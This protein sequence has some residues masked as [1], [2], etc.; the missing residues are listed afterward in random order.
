[1]NER[2]EQPEEIEHCNCCDFEETG[3]CT[4]EEIDCSCCSCFCSMDW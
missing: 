3:E 4:C 2:E 1:M